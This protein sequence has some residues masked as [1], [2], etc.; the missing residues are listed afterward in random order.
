MGGDENRDT[1][2][3]GEVSGDPDPGVKLDS[4]RIH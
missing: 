1:Y 4:D 2:K 3:R